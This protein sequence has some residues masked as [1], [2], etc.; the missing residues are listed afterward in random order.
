MKK[1]V[2]TYSSAKKTA[3]PAKTVVKKNTRRLKE[4]VEAPI[5]PPVLQR[6][7]L[8]QKRKQLHQLRH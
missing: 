8:H 4:Q 7:Q 1:Q 3:T 6:K 5:K 2:K